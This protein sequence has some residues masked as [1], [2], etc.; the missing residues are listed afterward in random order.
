M[1]EAIYGCVVVIVAFVVYTTNGQESS[2]KPLPVSPKQ[3]PVYAANRTNNITQ[4]SPELINVILGNHNK[5]RIMERYAALPNLT[6]SSVLAAR[7][8]LWTEACNFSHQPAVVRVWGENMAALGATQSKQIQ[9]ESMIKKWADEKRYNQGGT[10]EECC[11]FQS[12]MCCHYTQLVWA[13]TTTV[14]CGY[15]V[16]ANLT[17]GTGTLRNVAYLACYYYPPG[18]TPQVK[19]DWR[20]Y[21]SLA[22]T[23]AKYESTTRQAKP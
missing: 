9:L 8:Q 23:T 12:S 14:G 11:S 21:Q 16:C 7:A 6:W 3:L 15:N 19:Y 5:P 1:K 13:K 10:F 20:P 4:L 17:H 2:T 18:N 22:T